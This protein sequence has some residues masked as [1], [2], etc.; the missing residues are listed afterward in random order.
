MALGWINVS[1][2]GEI[3]HVLDE[4]IETEKDVE[5]KR[6][7]VKSIDLIFSRYETTAASDFAST[8]IWTALTACLD[9]Y[10]VDSRGDVGS[11]IRMAACESLV[12]VFKHSN[13]KDIDVAIGRMLRLSVE[14]MDRVRSVAGR[15]ICAVVAQWPGAPDLLKDFVNRCVPP[16]N[17]YDRADRDMFAVPSKVYPE[18]VHMISLET[19]QREILTGFVVSAGGLGESLV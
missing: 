17:S 6:N 18:A 3:L 10:T 13:P 7:A 2:A 15:C 12:S 9:D 11:W 5:V 16:L 14:K 1:D 19:Y 4:I 8:R